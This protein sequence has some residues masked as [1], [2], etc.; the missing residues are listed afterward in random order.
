MGQNTSMDSIEIKRRRLASIEAMKR[1]EQQE[2]EDLYQE[3]C[4]TLY[5]SKG[6]CCA[7]CDHWMSDKGFTGECE[8]AGIVSG[9][10]VMRS[11]GFTFC[12]YVPSPGFPIT[13]ADHRCGKFKD[14]FDWSTLDGEYLRRIGAMKNGVLRPKP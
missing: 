3:R 9:A 11:L 6:R 10:D 7:G 12:S 13:K 5:W 2:F 8:A 1:I 4:D 14:D